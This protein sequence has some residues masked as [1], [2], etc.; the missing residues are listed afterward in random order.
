MSFT[1]CKICESRSESFGTYKVLGKFEARYMRCISC[2]FLQAEEPVWLSEAY[3]TP[4]NSLDT[5]CISRTW[6]LASVTS[7][8]LDLLIRKRGPFLDFGGGYGVFVRH[9]RDSGYD[10]RWSDRYCE[11][12]F[13]RGFEHND[14]S[15]ATYDLLTLFEVAE[16]LVNPTE[17]FVAMH[18]LSDSILFTTQLVPK[19][20]RS[21]NDWHY[22]GIEHGQHVAF[23]TTQALKCLASKLGMHLASNG[24]NIHLFAKT[25]IVGVGFRLLTKPRLAGLV[26]KIRKRRPLTLPDQEFVRLE[27]RKEKFDA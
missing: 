1:R 3:A 17:V 22:S 20:L 9:M 23:F 6:E 24:T 21:L 13:A 25:P 2:G 5:G 27:L 7:A 26:A 15:G 19:S 18:K 16:H 11:N 4:I 14:A 12:L 8:V 10:F